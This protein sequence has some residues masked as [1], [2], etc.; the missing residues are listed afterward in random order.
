MIRWIKESLCPHD[1]EKVHTTVVPEKTYTYKYTGKFYGDN[2]KHTE[3]GYVK[4]L[5]VCSDCG[6]RV[7]ETME[8]NTLN[9]ERK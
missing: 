9:E 3:G 6:K 4:V 2:W 1:W 7:I 8:G 5:L